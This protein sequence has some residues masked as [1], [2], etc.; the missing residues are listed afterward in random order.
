MKVTGLNVLCCVIRAGWFSN[1]L[2]D[3]QPFTGRFSERWLFN[4][5]SVKGSLSWVLPPDINHM[6]ILSFFFIGFLLFGACSRTTVQYVVHDIP[7][8]SARYSVIYIVHADADYLYHENAQPR[9]ADQEALKD[10]FNFAEKAVS[11][12]VFVFHQKPEV[13]QFFI[14]PQKDREMFYFRRG[15]LVRHQTYSPKDGGFTREAELYHQYS[16][17]EESSP[18]AFLYFGHE[19]PSYPSTTYHRSMKG[20]LFGTGVFAEGV[21]L[22]HRK[23]DLVMISTCNNGNPLMMSKLDDRAGI[24]VASPQNLHLSY[25]ESARLDLLEKRPDIPLLAVA[26]SI[27]T[28][29]F[30][31][32]TER[33]QTAVSVSIYNLNEMAFSL[34]GFESRYEHYLNQLPLSAHIRENTD[35]RNVELFDEVLFSN[36]LKSYYRPPAF[37]LKA[38]VKDHS[39]WGCKE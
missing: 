23:V 33:T 16:A 34:N 22:F 29:S 28:D 1:F 10:A 35:C 5:K 17:A 21:S 36:G 14:I 31:A 3:P 39:G 12:E 15:K 19:V 26:D 30:K 24:V 38:L 8:Q 37:G 18:S 2:F 6:R 32:L 13:K 7:A 20:A 4:L 9:Y 27:A 25:M 11:G